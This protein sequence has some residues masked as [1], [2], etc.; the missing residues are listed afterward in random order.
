MLRFEDKIL[1]TAQRMPEAQGVLSLIRDELFPF[2]CDVLDLPDMNVDTFTGRLLAGWHRYHIKGLTADPVFLAS[3]V[4]A[5]ANLNLKMDQLTTLRRRI[6]DVNR[7]LI[8]AVTAP[9]TTGDHHDD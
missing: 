9:T 1:Y 7:R 6:E 3:V 8:A 2:W 4:C 5:A